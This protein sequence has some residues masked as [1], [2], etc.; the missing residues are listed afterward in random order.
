M[1]RNMSFF[2]TQDQIRSRTKTVTRRIGWDFLRPGEIVNACEKCQGLGKGEK[3]VKI[4]QVRIL[5]VREELLCNMPPLDCKKEGF[6]E[7]DTSDFIEMFMREM[8]CGIT[9]VVN[10][11][12]FEYI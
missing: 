9:T 2:L 3:I 8:K 7:M 1:P 5:H 12:E 10:R 11:I 6:P 4:C